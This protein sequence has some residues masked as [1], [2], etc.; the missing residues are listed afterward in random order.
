MRRQ[1]SFIPKTTAAATRQPDGDGRE[2]PD[3]AT[4]AISNPHINNT[5]TTEFHMG[6]KHTAYWSITAFILAI[7]MTAF[8]SACHSSQPA[9]DGHPSEKSHKAKQK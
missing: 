6:I 3:P 8:M 5:Q 1:K 9:A 2:K 4:T 7:I